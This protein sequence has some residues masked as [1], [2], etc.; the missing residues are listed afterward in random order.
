MSSIL[1][2][3][4]HGARML[5]KTPGFTGMAVLTL[6]LAIGANSAIFSLLDAAVLRPLPYPDSDA[7]VK[8]HLTFRS[9]TSAEIGVQP[10]WSYPKFEV[11]RDGASLFDGVAA[12]ALSYYNL[13]GVKRPERL[14]V[15][16]VSASYF[17]ILG[18]DAVRGRTFLATED[19]VSGAH[20]VVILAHGLWQN[21]YGGDPSVLGRSVRLG[22]TVLEIVGIMPQGFAGLSGKAQLWT[23]MAMAPQLSNRDNALTWHGT[24]WHEI[25]ARVRADTPFPKA[26]AQVATLG[27]RVAEQFPGQGTTHGAA[28]VPLNSLRVD[29]VMKDT[30]LV[31]VAAVA[32]LLVI[33]CVNV[34]GLLLA[35]ATARK[36]EFSIRLAV[37]ASPGRLVR[38]LLTEGLLLSA[39]GG[40]GALLL[41]V[42]TTS[43]LTAL[44]PTS[45]N[46]LFDVRAV[47]VGWRVTLFTLAISVITGIVFAVA[48]AIRAS[49][50][51]LTDALKSGG[52]GS[53]GE[54]GSG[55]WSSPRSLLVAGQIALAIVLLVGAGL[56]LQ[57]FSR[58][59]SVDP[60]FTARNVLSLRVEPDLAEPRGPRALAFKEE[61][62]E[63]LASLPGVQGVGLSN[64]APLSGQCWITSVRH[65]DG[66]A[67]A[68]ATQ[69]VVGVQYV[70]PDHFATL[71][72]A[73][74]RGRDFQATDRVGAPLVAVINET[75]ARKLWPGE[76]P[77]GRRLALSESLFVDGKTAEVVGVVADVKYRGP[78]EETGPDVYLPALQ[79]GP[80]RLM[81]FLKT[82]AD[83]TA[84]IPA[85]R[86][87]VLA[88]DPNLPIYD[89]QTMGERL[90]VVTAGARFRSLLLGTFAG[91]ALLLSLIG[92][93]GVVSYRVSRRAREF[94][95]RMALGATPADLRRGVVGWALRLAAVGIVVG[96]LA[97]LATTRALSGLL[98]GVTT[99]D[100]PTF[101]GV[102]LLLGV[103]A[104]L[105]S[106]VPALRATRVDPTEVL[107]E[108]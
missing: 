21:R 10:W 47:P 25:I 15:E 13:T 11:L 16:T 20:P 69:P 107:R 49:R 8:I 28:A 78:E 72:I 7:L 96:M 97:A 22:E 30:L 91:V 102:G 1:L 100:A 46:Y 89:I 62:V 39:L 61:L 59:R 29:P 81:A 66:L 106:Y 4:R 79:S 63:R 95:I 98:F 68:P 60:G 53:A 37:G 48:P 84:L 41:A 44:A 38:Q 105:A 67:L 77:L 75:A 24:H 43:G 76:N 74:R 80:T 26:A 36:R 17:S 108:E 45:E 87:E 83:P 18:V 2:D 103:V 6:A 54:P 64:C 92:L 34:A 31:L 71:G 32:I 14:A 9:D 55:L 82:A 99:T 90:T 50:A 33:G 5:R 57:S 93:Y 12:Y 27:Q 85:I 88:I 51:H 23:P 70:G 52:A 19:A 101:L 94:G 65:L 3:L 56:M 104:S 73:R 58:L 86:A 40:T 35:R 42:W